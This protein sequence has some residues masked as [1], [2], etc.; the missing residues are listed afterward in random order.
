VESFAEFLFTKTNPT[1]TMVKRAP[2][3]KK[4]KVSATPESDT[5]PGVADVVVS[6]HLSSPSPYVEGYLP[7]SFQ[8]ISVALESFF[9]DGIVATQKY[10]ID[11]QMKDALK[12]DT[13]SES[14]FRWA[15]YTQLKAKGVNFPSTGVKSDNYVEAQLSKLLYDWCKNSKIKKEF[16]KVDRILH[17]LKVTTLSKPDLTVYS[18]TMILF[19][20]VKNHDHYTTDT[21]L[22]QCSLY[23]VALLYFIRVRIGIP[24]QSVLGFYVCG[25]KCKH[26]T[27]EYAVGLVKLTAPTELGGSIVAQNCLSFYK[28]KDLSGIQL[29]LN[30]LN[31][32]I[33]HEPYAK[34]K[35]GDRGER[36][37]KL[38]TPALLVLPV[39]LWGDPRLIDNGTA[40]IVFHGKKAEITTIFDYFAISDS[41]WVQFK[42]NVFRYLEQQADTTTFYI[43]VRTKDSTLRSNPA[44]PL[45]QTLHMLKP[46][47]KDMF[48]SLVPYGTGVLGVFFMKDCGRRVDNNYYDAK[49]F[50]QLCDNFKKF[51]DDVMELCVTIFHGDV[52]PHNIVITDDDE[53]MLI[54]LDEGS[55]L[56]EGT[57]RIITEDGKE[58][59]P[60]LRYPNI[61]CGWEH[62]QLYTQIQLLSTFLY[63]AKR[64]TKVEENRKKKFNEDQ[65]RN[66]LVRL[67]ELAHEVNSY[68]QMNNE[69]PTSYFNKVTPI[70]DTVHTMQ[71]L[72]GFFDKK[73][74]IKKELNLN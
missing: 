53:F 56:T 43:K 30:F 48:C 68:L 18:R 34:G 14:D 38:N 22:A 74:E 70:T 41:N 72:L 33:T 11:K 10:R 19:G 62:R 44:G 24:V 55:Y 50:S 12:N 6:A 32:G 61:L 71:S 67:R 39:Q 25:C 31:S 45:Q 49:T 64:I 9:P 51:Y 59:L 42:S 27:D 46:R 20:E 63:M 23:L 3:K 60:Y 7:A 8:Q 58:K 2:R 15:I 28:T 36:C 26:L 21:A 16:S 57:R 73:D 52:L 37:T 47:Y 1:V 35:L 54:D 5:Q 69:K 4:A 40:S 17:G 65:A 13:I 66:E 29:L